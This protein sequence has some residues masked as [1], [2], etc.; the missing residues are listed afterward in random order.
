[1]SETFKS[2]LGNE[3]WRTSVFFP[4]YERQTREGKNRRAYSEARTIFYDTTIGG[5]RA[6]NSKYQFGR[7]TDPKIQGLTT[8]SKGMGR[9]YYEAIDRNQKLISLQCGTPEFN[10]LSQYL[11][12]FFNPV[13][14]TLVNKGETGRLSYKIGKTLGTL[15]TLP[16]QAWFAFQHTYTKVTAALT[17]TPYSK[18]YYMK[19]NMAMYWNGVQ[20]MF[21]ALLV[22]MGYVAP[23]YVSTT[24]AGKNNN[25]NNKE[26]LAFGALSKIELD[27]MQRMLPDILLE[28]SDGLGGVDV[29]SVA[30]RAQRL[31]WAHN[32]VLQGYLTDPTTDSPEAYEEKLVNYIN[33]GATTIKPAT[34]NWETFIRRHMGEPAY[35]RSSAGS[36]ATAEDQKQIEELQNKLNAITSAQNP[37]AEQQAQ[38]AS[39]RRQIEQANEQVKYL[40]DEAEQAALQAAQDGNNYTPRSRKPSF[41]EHMRAN[42]ADGGAFVTFAAESQSP[43]E[44]FTNNTKKPA[45]AEKLDGITQAGRDLS[46]TLAEGKIFK[47][48][49]MISPITGLIKGTLDSWGIN[50]GP[51]AGNAFVDMPN[52]WESSSVDFS[53]NSYS[54]RLQTPYGNKFSIL[55]DLYLPLIMLINI[56]APRSTGK[57][58]YTSPY[59]CSLFAKGEVHARLGMITSLTVSRAVGNL[60]WTKDRLPNAIDVEFTY[61]N[62]DQIMHLPVSQGFSD[63]TLGRDLLTH[64]DEPSAYTD[65]ISTLASMSLYHKYYSSSRFDNAWK[66]TKKEFSRITSASYLASVTSTTLPGQ[67]LTALAPKTNLP[68]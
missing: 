22:D 60:K 24:D 39:L 50:L 55:M 11:G 59:L 30:N 67:I 4:P 3:Q 5:N 44:S 31:A 61:T 2:E 14:S 65:Y 16:L 45:I 46:Y 66:K 63:T 41:F 35:T 32:Q 36:S 7:L 40:T 1:M 8:L 68:Q 43:T 20:V 18:F 58:S 42:A 54:I 9:G 57:A 33:S 62:L 51:F 26:Q 19:A 6:I 13:M 53:Q 47:L 56:V 38:V 28:S 15:F 49:E 29:F 21:N 17:G 23:S 64:F 27:T 52:T 48:Q 12:T 34:S 37:T 25:D 10:A